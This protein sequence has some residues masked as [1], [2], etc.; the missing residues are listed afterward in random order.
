MSIIKK[1]AEYTEKCLQLGV[2]VGTDMT[3][4]AQE[5]KEAKADLIL[6]QKTVEHFI[7]SIK[8]T[9]CSYCGGWGHLVL[10][11]TSF[12]FME[13]HCSQSAALKMEWGKHKRT[14]IKGYMEDAITATMVGTK[15][16]LQKMLL[17]QLKSA[18]AGVDAMVESE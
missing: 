5:E 6:G 10:K 12:K 8:D 9:R 16:S 15:R 13:K 3:L 18:S 2:P 17:E 4:T 14:H 11:C 1:R 7:D